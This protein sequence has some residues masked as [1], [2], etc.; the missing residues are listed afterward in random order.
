[1]ISIY[2]KIYIS[3]YN[4]HSFYPMS[5]YIHLFCLSEKPCII[6]INEFL[7]F[8]FLIL[9]FFYYLTALYI[10]VAL[11]DIYNS[12]TGSRRIMFLCKCFINFVVLTKF[13]ECSSLRDNVFNCRQYY[14]DLIYLLWYYFNLN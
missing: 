2:S 4:I 1:M 12:I 8:L 6:F 3:I 5:L 9:I 11:K 10:D 13:S 14:V 7:F